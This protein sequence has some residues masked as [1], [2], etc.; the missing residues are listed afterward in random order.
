[1]I[2]LALLAA[3]SLDAT[4]IARNSATLSALGP[5]P[6]GSPRNQ[7]AAQFVAAKLGEAGLTQIAL[8]P[9]GAG[10]REGTNVVASLPGRSDRLLI[11]ATHHDSSAGLADVSDRSRSLS[12]LIE[13]GR[14]AKSL[15]RAKTWILASFDGGASTGE[16][17]DHYLEGLGKSRDL[18]DAVVLIE[19]SS[20]RYASGGPSLIV[21]ACGA[22][23]TGS[24][25]G[26]A[27]RDLVSA[28]PAAFPGRRTSRLATP[29]S[30][31]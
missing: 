28:A 27:G 14:Q 31:S 3:V 25:R 7:A 29:A 11:M 6:F 30:A 17:I 4:A 23:E 20:A 18:I 21:P 19:V 24:S 15:E 8:D 5:H 13:I 12:L 2:L 9:F 22:G 10:D 26:M 1:M 16:G